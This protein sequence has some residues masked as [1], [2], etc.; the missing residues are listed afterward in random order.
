MISRRLAGSFLGLAVCLQ[1]A[2]SPV[3]E[4]PPNVLMVLVD[5]LNTDLGSYGH[6]MV[7]TPSIDRLAGR[8]FYSHGLTRNIHSVI[9]A[10]PVC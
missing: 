10:A 2:C 5:D 9:K 3:A 7:Q 8:G 1:A 4:L 6:P